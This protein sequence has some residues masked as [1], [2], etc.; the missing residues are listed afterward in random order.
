M[1]ENEHEVAQAISSLAAAIEGHGYPLDGGVP[2]IADSIQRVSEAVHI[3]AHM[4]ELT[5]AIC[6]GIRKGLFGS[7]A[8]DDASILQLADRL[9][10][11]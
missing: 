9:A 11:G 2:G 8:T 6:M 3:G 10:E 7:N 4:D 5:H 1:K